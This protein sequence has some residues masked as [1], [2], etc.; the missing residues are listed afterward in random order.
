MYEVEVVQSRNWEVREGLRQGSK[1]SAALLPSNFLTTS[2][3]TQALRSE[4]R[5][6][7]ES[8]MI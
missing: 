3:Y 6:V 8:W 5:K 2:L 4:L 1:S 7:C